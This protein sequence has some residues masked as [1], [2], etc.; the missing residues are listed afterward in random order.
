MANFHTEG[1]KQTMIKRRLRIIFGTLIMI[2]EEIAGI[3]GCLDGPEEKSAE[4][5]STASSST[6]CTER[7]Q[8]TVQE[9]VLHPIEMIQRSS[10]EWCLINAQMVECNVTANQPPTSVQKDVGFYP[11]H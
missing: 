11:R 3:F 7:P 10:S 9:T 6:Q 4:Y 5:T 2:Y 8:I 1:Y